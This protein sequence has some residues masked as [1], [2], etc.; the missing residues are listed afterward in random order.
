ME[1]GK[2]KGWKVKKDKGAGLACN[3]IRYSVIVSPKNF[4][5]DESEGKKS[6]GGWLGG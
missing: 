5:T 4:G 2:R 6:R 1:R 3:P